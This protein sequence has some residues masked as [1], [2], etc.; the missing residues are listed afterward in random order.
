M[1][2]S[3]GRIVSVSPG[4]PAVDARVEIDAAEMTVLPGLTETH[5]HLMSGS[6]ADSAEALDQ[7]MDENIATRLR[8][9]LENGFTTIMALGDY[10]P[11]IVEIRQKVE[12][13]ELAGPRVLAT[14]PG[15]TAPDDWPV[16]IKGHS[17]WSRAHTVVELADPE[18][19]RTKVR[20]FA[21]A[22]VD[23][24]KVVIDRTIVP[25]ATLSDVVLAA[26]IDEAHAAGLPVLVHAETVEDM[27]NA[28]NHGADRLV[29]TPHTGSIADASGARVLRD[30]GVPIATTAS[31]SS[32]EWYQSVGRERTADEAAR[33]A[34]ILENIRHLWDEGATVAFGTDSPPR[35]D[36]MTEVRALS[37]VLSP[38][39][40]V[41]A[42]T[43]NAAAFVD[44]DDDIGTLEEGKIADVL[45]VDGDPLADISDLAKVQI[46]IKSGQVVVDNQ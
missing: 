2:I 4:Q 27:I 32:K 44:L 40:I 16:P 7:W 41:T 18:I 13:G 30:A 1:V 42:L 25:D 15:F 17:S 38:E 20:E 31:F 35:V 23:G 14:G 34:Q 46:V 3:D 43:S 11:A 28:V 29:H 19:A 33:H 22:N 37:A 6:R 26:I 21:N 5:I 8:A 9:Y 36:Y 24:I 45:I 39:E 10:I 12:D